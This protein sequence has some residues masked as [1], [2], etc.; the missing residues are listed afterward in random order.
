MPDI[1]YEAV[2]RAYPVPTVLLT[3][4]FRILD[5]NDAWLSIVD[6]RPADVL[7]QNIFAA[8]PKD[9]FEPREE[10]PLR[11]RESLESVVETGEADRLPLMRYDIEDPAEPGVFQERYWAVINAP[12]PGPN[13]R[14]KLIVHRAADA[15]A[16]VK[17]SENAKAV[18]G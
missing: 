14:P 17:Q 4:D 12:V 1:D 16:M 15:T 8:F 2:F 13:G 18:S 11:L 7:G 10:G 5:A 6:R 9:K 3:C